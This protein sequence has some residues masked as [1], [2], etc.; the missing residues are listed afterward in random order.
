M[1]SVS[2]GGGQ[3]KRKFLRL[4]LHEQGWTNLFVKFRSLSWIAHWFSESSSLVFGYLFLGERR[5][6]RREKGA[7]I[8]SECLRWLCPFFRSHPRSRWLCFVFLLCAAF[9]VLCSWPWEANQWKLA[10]TAWLHV[11]PSRLESLG[12]SSR[13]LTNRSLHHDMK[14]YGIHVISH[15]AVHHGGIASRDCVDRPNMI[16]AHQEGQVTGNRSANMHK[17]R[18]LTLWR[19]AP[20]DLVHIIISVV[21]MT[22]RKLGDC[23]T[24]KHRKTPTP[25]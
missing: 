25:L 17:S 3:P 19:D 22:G 14:I 20:R 21:F 16:H 24:T 1:P 23:P 2:I 15:L 10:S 7:I 13:I 8:I 9:H 6:K 5:R 11:F 18:L 12:Y 4:L